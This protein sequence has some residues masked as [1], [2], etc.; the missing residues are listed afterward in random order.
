MCF[1]CCC[2]SERLSGVISSSS[3]PGYLDY[4]LQNKRFGHGSLA[5]FSYLQ[6]LIFS[7]TLVCRTDDPS[8]EDTCSHSCSRYSNRSSAC[9]RRRLQRICRGTAMITFAVS[10]TRP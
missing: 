6:H 8:S 3:C 7:K 5:H 1:P 4:P 10:M 2:S 9:P